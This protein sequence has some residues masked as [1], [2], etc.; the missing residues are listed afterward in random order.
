ME[1]RVVVTGLGA[2]SP[3]GLSVEETWQKAVA[4]ISGV[5]PITLFDASAFQV[6]I[7]CE[8]KGF[9]AEEWMPAREAGRRDGFEKFASAAARQ[10]IQQA[11]LQTSEIQSNRVGVIVSSAIGGLTSLQENIFAM[12]AEGARRI[13]PFVI[14]MMM[15]NG[16]AGLVAIDYG[17][18]GPCFSV[19][20]ACA[21]GADG[22]GVAWLLLRSG[23]IDVA[24][25]GGAEATITK[26][27]IGAF[28]RLGAMSR[29]NEDYGNTPKP[30]DLERD[31][32]VMGEGAAIM[33]LETESHAR[34]RGVV[35]LAELAGYGATA[36]A[37]H[38]TAPS[39]DGVGGAQAITQALEAGK[40]D[41]AEVG[42]INAHGTA[43]WLNDISETKA[44]KQVFGER[45]YQIPISSTKSMTGHMMGATG[46]LEALFCI[47]AV[48]EKVI[49]PT[50]NYQTPDPEC[51]LDYVPN[52]AREKTVKVALSNAFGFGGHN[53]VL[54]IREY[55]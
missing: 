35:I 7:A 48:R 39:E 45:A 18:R 16:A 47:Q 2:V 11:G 27:A 6:R 40:I 10:A 1:E 33:V 8:V 30:F 26:I 13:S 55:N 54:A 37:F 25:A 42:Y 29:R 5:G 21:S 32:L 43:T 44:I 20:S 31:G 9:Q 19:A 34:R 28:D 15:A 41:P 49:P 22:I 46:A 14:P 3:L 52:Q 24:V 23:V 12:Q 36:D 38:I 50:I 17:Y 51:D 53:T 4:G